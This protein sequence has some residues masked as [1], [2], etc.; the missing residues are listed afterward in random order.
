MKLTS[1]FQFKK[2][3]TI[4]DIFDKGSKKRKRDEDD[5]E[6]AKGGIKKSK[7]VQNKDEEGKEK[8]EDLTNDPAF[9]E[10]MKLMKK[11]SKFWENDD[12]TVQEGM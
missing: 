10:Y 9:K 5:D 4:D 6:V 1:F 2:T 12:G 7:T 11:N 3:D 8:D